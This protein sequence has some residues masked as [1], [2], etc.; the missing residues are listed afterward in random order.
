M[1][2]AANK[3]RY[4]TVMYLENAFDHVPVTVLWWALRSLGVEEWAVHVIQGMYSNVR[5]HVQVKGQYSEEF[6]LW[7]GDR[8]SVFIPLRWVCGTK[9]RDETPSA[10]LLQKLGI[11]D[12]TSVHCCWQL[13]WYGHVQRT[14]SPAKSITNFVIPGTRKQGRHIKTLCECEKNDGN[15]CGLDGID[16][17][18][19]DTRRADVWHSLVLPTP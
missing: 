7:F 13:R 3:L 9:D 14:M 10:S 15:N 19:I 1:S 12:I 5:S 16:R 17:Q 18:D 6:G 4:F 2:I 8:S 11:E